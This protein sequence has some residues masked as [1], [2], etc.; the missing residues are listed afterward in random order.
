[1]K[2]RIVIILLSLFTAITGQSAV[3]TATVTSKTE[4][5]VTGDET[6]LVEAV[7]E[8]TSNYKDRITADN[9]AKL[10]ILHLPAGNIDYIA[11]YMHSNKTGGAGS[12]SLNLND[13]TIGSVADKKFSEWPG[14]TSFVAEYV[15][16]YFSGNCEVDDGATLVLQV[17]ASANSLYFS[18][19]EISMS[20]AEARPYTV[21]LNWNTENGD[22]QTALTE[23][24]IGAGVILPECALSSFVL[25]GEDWVFAG[26]TDDRILAKMKSAPTM[27]KAGQVF[28][29]VRNTPLYAVYRQDGEE[30]IIMQDTLYRSGEYAIVMRGGEAEYWMA[31]G[32]VTNKSLETNACE[33]EMQS[34]KR[35][36]LMA[37]SVPAAARYL[38]EFYGETLKISNLGT[39]TSIGHNATTLEANSQEWSWMRGQNHSAA[40]YFAPVL[41]NDQ[42]EAKLLLPIKKDLAGDM[43]FQVSTMQLPEN[44]EYILLF[45]VTDVPTSGSSTV[46]TTHP[47]GWDKLN[48]LTIE[49]KPNKKLQNG[50]L[51]IEKDG[52]FFDLF[53]RKIN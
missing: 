27:V 22:L 3:I 47:F 24:S 38:V 19:I 44:Y 48:K 42:I 9:T 21:T 45:D 43:T 29:P 2:N 39:S 40:M 20:E 36:R 16:I 13:V 37:N 7:F 35:Y 46:W 41:K 53:G 49:K 15:P 25:D 26:W 32:G 5:K 30:V 6:G 50:I 23:K 10:S 4:A 31:K 33:V 12:L 11:V 17:S 28:Y 14:Q 34:D 18:K 51:L 1:M 52:L 8:T